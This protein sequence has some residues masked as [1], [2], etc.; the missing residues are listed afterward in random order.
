MRVIISEK[1][2]Q[3]LKKFSDGMIDIYFR[4]EYVRLYE[5]EKDQAFCVIC[6]SENE[7]TLMPFLRRR[8]GQYYDFETAYGYGGPIFNTDSMEWIEKSLE[9]IKDY[10]CSNGY[11]CGFIRFHPLI[12]NAEMC[13]KTIDVLTDRKTI[14][15]ELQHSVEDIWTGQ[16]TS[17]NRNM[18]RKAEKNGLVYRAE[19]EYTSLHEFMDLYNHTMHRLNAES[20]Y[21]FTESYYQHFKNNIAG[22]GFLGIVSLEGRIIGAALFMICGEYGHYHLAGSDRSLS[23]LGINNYLIWNTALEMKKRGVLSFHLGGGNSSGD[24][25]SLYRFKKAFGKSENDFCI[26][27]WVFN[28]DAYRCVCMRWESDHPDLI[29]VFGD[30]LLKYRYL[31]G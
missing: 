29:P 30:R 18:I 20:F 15:I 5:N 2:N 1:W 8:I 16:I 27:K 7:L 28:E 22:S 31:K 4:E 21:Y 11:L 6:E 14:K 24:T 3:Y 17:K 19:Y 25:D 10:F 26:G 23:S 12:K 9:A 13:K